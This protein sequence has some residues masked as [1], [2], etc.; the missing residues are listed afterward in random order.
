MLPGDVYVF[1]KRKHH[2]I[3]LRK[4]DLSLVVGM[5]ES[6]LPLSPERNSHGDV[7]RLGAL[8]VECSAVVMER[9]PV[10]TVSI[11]VESDPLR[12]FAQSKILGHFG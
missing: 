10:G 1:S 2:S 8:V 7:L 12:A 11:P 5:Q 6:Q 3:G 9:L 4:V